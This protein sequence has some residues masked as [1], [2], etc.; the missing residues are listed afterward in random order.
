MSRKL[1]VIGGIYGVVAFVLLIVLG[2]TASEYCFK[3]TMVYM[4]IPVLVA[5]CIWGIR[6]LI[7]DITE[8]RFNL[9]YSSRLKSDF[10]R[11]IKAACIYSIRHAEHFR[12]GILNMV[13]WS[14]FPAFVGATAY[15]LI[16]YILWGSFN[17]L[18]ALA[19]AIVLFML[20]WVDTVVCYGMYQLEEDEPYQP[21][22]WY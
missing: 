6:E 2:M 19:I 11:L 9:L 13:L 8:L 5:M 4:S 17:L 18:I 20:G 15:F 21:L 1:K 22:N 7:G 10:K 14:M 16:F 12:F 3:R